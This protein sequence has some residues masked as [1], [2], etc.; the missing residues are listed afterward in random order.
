MDQMEGVSPHHGHLSH[1]APLCKALHVDIPQTRTGTWKEGF[2]VWK[3]P[4]AD[5]LPMQVRGNLG[6]R[7]GAPAGGQGAGVADP[8]FPCLFS[9]LSFLI[10]SMG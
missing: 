6:G 8:P 4:E 10:C 7:G 3:F 2:A 9:D 5:F 1:S